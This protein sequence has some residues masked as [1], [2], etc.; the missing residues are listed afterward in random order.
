MPTP[1]NTPHST[2]ADWARPVV[3][4]ASCL[5]LGF[6]AGWALRGGEDSPIIIP[7]AASEPATTT[8]ERPTTTAPATD[9][10]TTATT[11]TVPQT[12]TEVEPAAAAEPSLPDPA[13]IPV[14]VLNGSG[15]TG[16][17]GETAKRIEG[18]GYTGVTA[19]NAAATQAGPSIIYHRPGGDLAARRLAQ[20][21]GYA[22]TQ[23][24]PL[25][26]AALVSEAPATAQVILVLGSS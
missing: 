26:D 20:D 18:L 22:L 21:L 12:V 17:A 8:A 16:L 10:A 9:T 1:E 19:G 23:V 15:V 3:L 7:A 6:V 4:A 11:P 14:A 24:K 5:I 25:A 2:R 13:D